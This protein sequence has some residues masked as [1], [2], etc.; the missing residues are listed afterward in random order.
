MDNMLLR[1]LKLDNIDEIIVEW[2]Y[3][4]NSSLK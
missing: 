3:D 1:Y 2:R 4:Y